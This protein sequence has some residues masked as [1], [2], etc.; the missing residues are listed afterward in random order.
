MRTRRQT[1]QTTKRSTAI[2]VR[3]KFEMR[4]ANEWDG[5]G[6]T[7]LQ[8]FIEMGRWGGARSRPRQQL[9]RTAILAHAEST[10]QPTKNL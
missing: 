10:A 3:E 9:Q 4:T 1:R 8:Y 2:V 5:G 6:C 7:A